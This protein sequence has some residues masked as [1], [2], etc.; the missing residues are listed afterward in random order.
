MIQRIPWVLGVGLA[1]LLLSSPASAYTVYVT[2]QGENTISIIDGKTKKV[3]ETVKTSQMQPHNAVLSKDGKK[4]YVANVKSGSISIF[5]TV[6][7]KEVDG[8]ML[9]AIERLLTEGDSWRMP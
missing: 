8:C 5:D 6:A 9:P 2:N 3:V 7:R 1:V 4:L